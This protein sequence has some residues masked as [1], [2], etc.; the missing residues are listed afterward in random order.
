M[1]EFKYLAKII[2]P[3]GGVIEMTEERQRPGK[4]KGA[5]MQ[6]SS[7]IYRLYNVRVPEKCLSRFSRVT[8]ESEKFLT[9]SSNSNLT[10]L[11]ATKVGEEFNLQGF[12]THQALLLLDLGAFLKLKISSGKHLEKTNALAPEVKEYLGVTEDEIVVLIFPNL[13][14]LLFYLAEKISPAIVARTLQPL[15]YHIP[16]KCHT[17]PAARAWLFFRKG[18]F[19]KL[20]ADIL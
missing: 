5:G 8:R 9:V 12:A 16:E 2:M 6:T 19:K 18:E 15:R 4:G 13:P 1:A 20:I 3:N 11:R 7:R 10:L 17:L 14:T